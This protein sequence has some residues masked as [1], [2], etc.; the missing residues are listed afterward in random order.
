MSGSGNALAPG[1]VKL[2]DPATSQVSPNCTASS[3]SISG[4]GTYTVNTNGSVT[5]DP[6]PAFT[7]TATSVNYQV[8]DTAG[9][10]ASAAIT[11]I[12]L[13]TPSGSGVV[14][15][16]ASSDTK[17]GAYGQAMTFGFS[18]STGLTGTSGGADAAGSA[19]VTS[20]SGS[21]T[22]S[23]STPALDPASVRLCS[24]GQ[25]LPNCTATSVGTVDGTYSVN[26][27]GSVTFTPASGFTGTATQPVAYQVSNTYTRTETTTTTSTTTVD[28][29]STCLSPSCS[30]VAAPDANSVAPGGSGYIPT[31]TLTQTSSTQ[32]AMGYAATA[33]L[34]PTISAP[35]GPSAANDSASTTAGTP[36]TVTPHSNDTAGSYQLR[37]SSILLCASGETAPA[38]TQTT[39][40]IAGQGTFSV[41]TASGVV[42]FTPVTG[43]TGTAAVPYRILDWNSSAANAV[44]T[45]TVT[46]APSSSGGG[47][48]AGSS[49]GSD[50][51]PS[52][53]SGSTSPDATNTPAPAGTPVPAT[54]GSSEPVLVPQRA[55]TVVDPD[56]PVVLDPLAD[57]VPS[58]G[59]RFRPG[60]VRIW[61]GD[62][63][64]RTHTEPGVGTWTVVDGQVEFMPAAGFTGTATI[65]VKAT[66]T[67]GATARAVLRVKVKPRAGGPVSRPAGPRPGLVPSVIDAGAQ[68]RAI[69]VTGRECPGV[70][71]GPTVEWITVAQVTVPIKAVSMTE[72]GVLAPPDSAKVAA[73]STRHASLDAA[74]GTSVLTW[75]ARFGAGCDGDLNVLLD[76]PTG[77]T[78]TITTLDG[79]ATR[80]RI[81]DQVSVAKGRHQAA[82][83]AQT[84][85]RRLTLL[86]CDGLTGDRFTRTA[87]IFATPLPPT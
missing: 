14:L 12:V 84:G 22:T 86:T 40:T 24:S 68:A 59:E 69:G 82:W 26:G 45:I 17:T 29:T 70:V 33:L 5:F 49:G 44:I 32:T 31:W 16:T 60:T 19:P 13:A 85:P 4:Q 25:V 64:V 78:F 54:A 34:T 53:A 46:E 63:W 61:D 55:V 62:S 7:G 6:E 2:C 38:C 39:V 27:D 43:F 10:K 15:P 71:G 37:P 11:P 72:S 76:Q 30:F 3:V 57:A 66:D 74:T 28:P 52:P 56:R 36:V 65:R 9:L 42:T 77:S 73:V 20:T 87:A 67:G 48:P 8:A 21:L 58:A 50:S 83:F 1:S 47:T 81:T 18:S 23:Y 79:Q 80:Y 51:D 35:S 75:H 41:D